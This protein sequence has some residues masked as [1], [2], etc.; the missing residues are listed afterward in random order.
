MSSFSP[1]FTLQVPLLSAFRPPRLW[2]QDC[3]LC[4][5]PA[6]ERLVCPACEAGLAGIERPCPGCALPVPRSGA[7]TA[8]RRHPYAFDAAVARFEY[9]FPLDRL[10][11]RFKYAGDLALGRWLALR[12]AE[13]VREQPRPDLLVAPPLA[14]PRL[15]ER[16]FNQAVEL[17]RTLG[18]ELGV[19]QD[20]TGLRRGRSTAPQ[21]G[22]GRRARQANLRG[23]FACRHP[24][25]GLHVAIVDD[26]MT[27]GATADL[28][29]R[30]LKS[31]GAA[32]VSAWAVAR[33][34]D[35]PR[36]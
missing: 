14:V 25:K 9:R 29:A 36:R 17:A 22:L 19:R 24:Y 10:V 35:V 27:T 4:L 33:A 12:L 34:P 8:C 2:S 30:V 5:E 15:R 7:C 11:Q 32:R 18:R 13:S 23:A 26:V 16:G 20:L 28:L 31:A 3:A 1:A 21:A 6:G